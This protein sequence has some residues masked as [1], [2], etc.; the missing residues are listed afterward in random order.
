MGGILQWR[1]LVSSKKV[2][3]YSEANT[4]SYRAPLGLMSEALT[5][6]Q[7][8]LMAFLSKVTSKLYIRC[9]LSRAEFLSEDWCVKMASYKEKALNQASEW[10]KGFYQKHPEHE[11]EEAQQYLEQYLG[12]RLKYIFQGKHLA[13]FFLLQQVY[14]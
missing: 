4:K 9:G 3:E 6:F 1:F 5:P 13:V 7:M 8:D 11:G 2:K 10:V 12:R 14:S